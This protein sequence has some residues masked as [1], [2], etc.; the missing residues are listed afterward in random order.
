MPEKYY[1]IVLWNSK[2][3]S[4]VKPETRNGRCCNVIDLMLFFHVF[5]KFIVGQL[6]DNV[7]W[8][9]GLKVSEFGM[10]SSVSMV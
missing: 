9:S 8:A 5:L 4:H 1:V 3:I 2:Y 7:G 10:S 6:C